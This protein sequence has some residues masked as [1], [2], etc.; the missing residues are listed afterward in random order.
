VEAMDLND[1]FETVLSGSIKDPTLLQSASE[2]GFVAM[3][4][5]LSTTAGFKWAKVFESGPR[6]FN[7]IPSL[8]FNTDGLSVVFVTAPDLMIVIVSVV[9]GSRL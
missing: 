6:N 2:G 9:D 3:L 1:D 4:N 7:S 5:D 8:A